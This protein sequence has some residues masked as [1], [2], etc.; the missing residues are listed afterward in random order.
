[1]SELNSDNMNNSDSIASKQ[2]EIDNATRDAYLYAAGM[3]LVVLSIMFL[4]AWA[5]YLAQNTGM[6]M[7][8]ITTGAIY[9]K[10]TKHLV[11]YIL[12]EEFHLQI[13]KLSHSIIGRLSIGYIVNL[14]SN[15]VQRFDLVNVAECA[16]MC[17]CVCVCLCMC[18]C[19][20]LCVCVCV[21]VCLCVCVCACVRFK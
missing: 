13:L 4:H 18:V 1:M 17:V 12:L 21:H 7:R 6:Q 3:I 15:D 11:A 9:H 20:H 5:F 14:A 19:V 2:E 8:I 16:C 10:V